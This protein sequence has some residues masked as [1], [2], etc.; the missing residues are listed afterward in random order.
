MFSRGPETFGQNQKEVKVAEQE[1]VQA[2]PEAE[3]SNPPAPKVFK[4]HGREFDISTDEG[5]KQAQTWS[6]AM[7][8][9]VGKQGNELGSLRE[10]VAPLRRYNLKKVTP[11]KIGLLSKVESLRSEGNHFEADKLLASYVEQ[12]EL[13]TEA[14]LERERLWNDYKAS[15]PEVFAVLPEDMAKSYVFAN[16]SDKIEGSDD[17]MGIIDRVLKPKASKLKPV[18]PVSPPAAT[19]SSGVAPATQ[20]IKPE[21]KKEPSA[22]DKVLD[23]FGF[24]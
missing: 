1:T 11:D 17:P 12:T 15:N 22:M 7:S 19:L 10:E 16:Y 14:T 3:K 5:F 23:E 9:L 21:D 6:E 18:S 13:A 8:T 20:T 4:V 2:K 24:R